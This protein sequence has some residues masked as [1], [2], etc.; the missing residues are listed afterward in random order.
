MPNIAAPPSTINATMVMTLISENQ[1]SPSAN[2][3]VEKTFSPKIT[4]QKTRHQT[5]TGTC[6]NQY[7]IQN[8]AAVK[9]E[10]SATVQVSQ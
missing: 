7:C 4:T 10:P 2:S 5:H 8:P 9:L 1:N 6:G 3:R